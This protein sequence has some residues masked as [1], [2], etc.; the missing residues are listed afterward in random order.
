[1]RG[2]SRDGHVIF[3]V[4]AYQFY[5]GLSD[6]DALALVADYATDRSAVAGTEYRVLR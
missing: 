3:P 2:V 4:M 6:D 5:H 1:M